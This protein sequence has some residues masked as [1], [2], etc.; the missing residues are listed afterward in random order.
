MGQTIH[1]I[2]LTLRAGAKKAKFSLGKKRS[3][4]IVHAHYLLMYTGE[5]YRDYEGGRLLEVGKLGTAKDN[6]GTVNYI[7]SATTKREYLFFE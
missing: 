3:S 1:R 4:Y 6:A 5:M 2:N 7:A